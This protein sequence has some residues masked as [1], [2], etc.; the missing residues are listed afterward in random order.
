[1]KKLSEIKIGATFEVAGSEFA[2]G[3]IFEK[4]SKGSYFQIFPKD[5]F[6][7]KAIKPRTD[8]EVVE[9]TA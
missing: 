3:K 9:V 5:I 4:T 7:G 6:C 8:I 1:M 2:K